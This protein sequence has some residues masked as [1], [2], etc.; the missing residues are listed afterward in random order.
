MKHFI[1]LLILTLLLGACCKDHSEII[2]GQNFIP[3]DVLDAIRANGQ[4]IYDGYNPPALKDKFLMSPSVLVSSNF[5]DVFA[6]GHQFVDAIIEF[7]NFN[8]NDLTIKVTIEEGT[9]QGEG[10]GSFISGV[11]NNF[12]VYVK[13]DTEDAT[14]HKIV[15]A[16]VFSGT[17]ETGGI[18]NLQRSVFMI[19]D[20]GDPNNDYIEIGQGRLAEDED[21]FS[22]KI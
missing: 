13:L 18:R 22:E 2:P 4:I 8:P 9:T 7:S 11:G 20:N 10:I 19:E 3:D 14:G 16:D 15:H 17:L 1:S 21:G 12:T 5:D 6:P